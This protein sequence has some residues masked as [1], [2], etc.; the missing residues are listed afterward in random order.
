MIYELREYS[1][2]E[3][4]G[5]GFSLY[6]NNFIQIFVISLLCQIPLFLLMNYFGIFD[7]E[8]ISF[9]FDTARYLTVYFAN[10]ITKLV[11]SAWI[12]YFVSQKFLEDS[13]IVPNPRSGGL[14]LLLIKSIII[15]IIV[16][17]LTLL[18]V[19]ALII[20]GIII[21]IGYSIAINILVVERKS[22][23]QSMKRSWILTRGDRGQIF[24]LLFVVGIIVGVFGFVLKM[25]VL[26][27]VKDIQ[28][29]GYLNMMLSALIEPINSCL[30]V[31]IYFNM[32]IKKEG[33]N[34]E[35][36]TGQFSLA[37]EAGP[38]MEG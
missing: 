21:A 31:V 33:F 28:W 1:F 22:I 38:T 29:M 4:I 20:P 14:I 15:S 36:L 35:H 5:K 32:R 17:F 27:L 13:S 8:E 2:G 3:T 24:G 34:I 9:T 37:K 26:Y 10:I 7:L 25:L 16:A 23:W 30:T 19:V 11:L 6:F 12:T 18:G